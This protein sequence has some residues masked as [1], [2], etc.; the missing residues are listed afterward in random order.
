M[1][2]KDKAKLVNKFAKKES[3]STSI[4]EEEGYDA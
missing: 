3:A 4:N 1:S 2:D